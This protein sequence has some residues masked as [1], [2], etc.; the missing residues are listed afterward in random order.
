MAPIEGLRL[1]QAN[2]SSSPVPSVAEKQ[3][4]FSGL[5]TGTSQNLC[6][7][8]GAD[9]LNFDTGQLFDPNTETNATCANNGNVILVGTPIPNNN[10]AAYRAASAT[11]TR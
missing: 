11:S 2:N 7:S 6:G 1:A 8:G 5:L 9:N 10:V 3:G 4:D